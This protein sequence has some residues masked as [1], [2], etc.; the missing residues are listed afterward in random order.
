MVQTKKKQ[1]EK[2]AKKRKR[3]AL[4]LSLGLGIPIVAGVTIPLVLLSGCK[5]EDNVI[6]RS[7]VTSNA[8]NNQVGIQE[9]ETEPAIVNFKCKF[10]NQRSERVNEKAV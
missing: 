6:V 5:A 10:Y 1:S 2:E 8:K 4:G 9:G 7:V 3:L